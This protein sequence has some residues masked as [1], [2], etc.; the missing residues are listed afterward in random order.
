MAN[1][2]PVQERKTGRV[3]GSGFSTGIG[4]VDSIVHCGPYPAA[5][6]FAATS[7]GT[8]SIRRLLRPVSDQNI[9]DSAAA[10]LLKKASRAR[11]QARRPSLV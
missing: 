11:L 6:N 8:V 9:F 2:L 3:L 7:V 5:T 10:R 4:V 1:L